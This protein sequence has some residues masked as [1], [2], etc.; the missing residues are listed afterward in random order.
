MKTFTNTALAALVAATTVAAVPGGASARDHWRDRDRYVSDW[1]LLHPSDVDCRDY[2]I[3]RNRWDD[4]RYRRW[5]RERHRDDNDRAAA[6]LFGLAAGALL[7]GTL[8]PTLGARSAGRD[9]TAHVQRCLAR[10][11]SYDPATNTYLGYD[12]LRH[13]C[14]L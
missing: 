14:R 13:P 2:R 1:C 11:R 3:N 7:G 10:Y 4:D 5:Y 8:A 12:G 9:V 6:A